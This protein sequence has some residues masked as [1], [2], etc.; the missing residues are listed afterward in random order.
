MKDTLDRLEEN[1][2]P[3]DP[4]GRADPAASDPELARKL[5][6]GYRDPEEQGGNSIACNNCYQT[7]K[8]I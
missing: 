6:E 7:W 1:Y 4:S 3:K 8:K 2:L 5:A